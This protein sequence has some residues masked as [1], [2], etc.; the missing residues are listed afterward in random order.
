MEVEFLGRRVQWDDEKN[1]LNKKKHGFTLEEARFVFAD[2]YRI[3]WFDEEHSDD[4]DRYKVLGMINNIVFV[5]YTE[6][7]DAGRLISARYATAKERRAYY[8]GNS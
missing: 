3:E 8:D 4:E 1:E 5:V 7:G 2:P 6:R